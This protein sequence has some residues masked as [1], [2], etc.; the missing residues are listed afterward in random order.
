MENKQLVRMRKK[1][2]KIDEALIFLLDER[3]KIVRVVG[4]IKIKAGLPI[5]NKERENHVLSKTQKFDNCEFIHLVFTKI[6]EESRRLQ[7]KKWK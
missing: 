3:A 6:I 5:L 7:E 2:D 1:I 4:E